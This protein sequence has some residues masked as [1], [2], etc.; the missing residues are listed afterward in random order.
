M[1]DS[2]NTLSRANVSKL[3]HPLEVYDTINIFIILRPNL[4]GSDNNNFYLATP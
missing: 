1:P 4:Y 2:Y 3:L